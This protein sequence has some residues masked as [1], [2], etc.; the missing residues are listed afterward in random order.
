ML[1]LLVILGLVGVAAGVALT[2]SKVPA[3]ASAAMS[4]M[5][6]KY[7][8][9]GARGERVF[10]PD[11]ATQILK[12][13]AS[14]LYSYPSQSDPTHVQIKPDPTGAPPSA[15]LSALNWARTQ[16]ATLTIMAP[17]YMAESSSA[18][19][20]L[21]A[22]APGREV[23][24]GGSLYAVLAYPGVLPANGL[25]PGR[26]AAPGA[27]PPPQVVPTPLS[28]ATGEIPPDLLAQ[29]NQL[30]QSGTDPN[31]LQFVASE[32]DAVGAGQSANLLRQKAASL[33]AV[34]SLPGLP[35][36]TPIVAYI[37]PALRAAQGGMPAA[38]SLIVDTP[39]GPMVQ[40]TQGP[41]VIVQDHPAAPAVVV[42][43]TAVQKAALA[44]NNALA[45]HG[46]KQ[47]DMPLYKAF[48]AAYAP[49]STPDGF[50]G[51]GT[52]GELSSTLGGMGVTMASVKVYP[53]HSSGGYD[54]V[55][56]P[57]QAEWSGQPVP[58]PPPPSPS[59]PTP[60]AV[61]V[62][63]SQLQSGS[64]PVVLAA[65]TTPGAATSPAS[66]PPPN[67][68]ALQSAAWAMNNALLANGYR[69]S[70]QPIYK[71]F[72]AAAG[73]VADG[74]PGSGTM[75]KLNAALTSMGVTM[76]PVTIYPWRSTGGYDG[77]NAPTAAE[78]NR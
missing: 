30:L 47:A 64:A 74:F 55:N 15:S 11:T 19:R 62:L 27:L 22:V 25:A 58:A 21:I 65:L 3:V 1:P 38:T 35:A 71:I 20:F 6:A 52:M 26:P 23:T 31:A 29:Y 43:P 24:D 14:Q 28:A 60:S 39:S 72:Q 76:A 56:A 5:M 45:A 41:A 61:Q 18:D 17:V 68:T 46:Y 73:G 10:N 59:A 44:M 78:W 13:L 53:W 77:V 54:G 36:S 51:T 50:P 16:N 8:T 9:A 7:T 32:L 57:T 12:T 70:D 37:S 66:A 40:T 75:G 69:K 33:Q 4:D 48:Q 49:G 2:R 34:S 42:V 63:Q 67:M